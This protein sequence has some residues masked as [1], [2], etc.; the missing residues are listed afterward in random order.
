MK[1]VSRNPQK[2]QPLHAAVALGR[3][4]E[5][6]RFLLAQGAP[7]DEPQAGGFTPLFSAAA[8]NDRG[9]VELL[10]NHGADASH[11]SDSGKTAADFARDRG[12]TEL[13]AWLESL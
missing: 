13:A 7:V 10:L 9:L 1:A 12:H 2:N 6:V 8:A 11:E 4:P 5:I 3:N